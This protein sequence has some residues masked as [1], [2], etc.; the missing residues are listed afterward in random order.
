M[1]RVF[2]IPLCMHHSVSWPVSKLGD[3]FSYKI[4]VGM[5]DS[6]GNKDEVLIRVQKRVQTPHIMTPLACPL[7]L[8]FQHYSKE[9]NY[10]FTHIIQARCLF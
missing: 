9:D 7:T 6:E 4:S 2:S 3:H 10:T 5:G 1:A 8:P